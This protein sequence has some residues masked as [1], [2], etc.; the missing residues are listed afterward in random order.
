MIR[1][2]KKAAKITVSRMVPQSD[3][4]SDALSP[5][6]NSIT[7]GPNPPRPPTSPLA[8][9]LGRRVISKWIALAAFAMAL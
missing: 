9:S 2:R 7:D 6:A 1:S 4:V 8:H 5:R 3:L